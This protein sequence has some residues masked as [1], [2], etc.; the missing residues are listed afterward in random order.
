V[1][2]QTHH[3]IAITKFIVIPGN[4][5][6]KVFVEGNAIS[7]IKDGRVGITVKVT[8][9]NMVLDIGCP[10]WFPSTIPALLPLLCHY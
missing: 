2:H 7:S 10:L 5:L 4:K 1:Y 9:D 3:P 6:D 8:G